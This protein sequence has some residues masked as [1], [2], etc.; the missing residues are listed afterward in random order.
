M[1]GLFS[2]VD[3]VSRGEDEKDP[4]KIKTTVKFQ[5]LK[6]CSSMISTIISIKGIYNL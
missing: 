3:F 6:L 2:S 1:I 4:N 5:S